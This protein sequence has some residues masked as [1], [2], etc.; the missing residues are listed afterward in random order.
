MASNYAKSVLSTVFLSVPQITYS[1]Y[2]SLL[3]IIQ[4]MLKSHVPRI[5]IDFSYLQ[6][7]TMPIISQLLYTLKNFSLAIIK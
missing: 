2:C 3:I 1:P 6:L 7:E 5:R 4:V